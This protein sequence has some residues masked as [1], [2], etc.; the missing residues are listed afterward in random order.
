MKLKLVTQSP[1]DHNRV[2]W[3]ESTV[4]WAAARGIA[5]DTHY[6]VVL[7]GEYGTAR[8]DMH[9]GGKVQWNEKSTMPGKTTTFDANT[10][11]CV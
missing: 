3:V 11:V 6:A 2:N 1:S 4:A 7:Y 9:G 10:T 5:R 8:F